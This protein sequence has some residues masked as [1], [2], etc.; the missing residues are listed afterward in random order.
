M[1]FQQL[2]SLTPRERC[3]RDEIHFDNALLQK[4]NERITFFFLI[5][6]RHPLVDTSWKILRNKQTRNFDIFTWT[7]MKSNKIYIGDFKK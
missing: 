7:L 1:K 5:T 6:Q 4:N 2:P 3:F